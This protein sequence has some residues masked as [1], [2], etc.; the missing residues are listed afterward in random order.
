M[1]DG[2][3][4]KGR[5][6]EGLRKLSNTCKSTGAE[7]WFFCLGFSAGHDAALLGEIARAGTDL[8]NF[9]YI[10]DNSYEDMKV[11]LVS[12]FDLVPGEHSIRAKLLGSMNSLLK[13]LWLNNKEDGSFTVSFNLKSADL[14]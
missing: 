7:I 12:I 2:Q 4:D 11:A 9:V 8:G 10:G 1:T 3:T 5:A 6:I 14:N 13:D